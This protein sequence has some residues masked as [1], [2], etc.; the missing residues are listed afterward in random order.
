[1]TENIPKA[2]DKLVRSTSVGAEQPIALQATNRWAYME[3]YANDFQDM[4]AFD[5]NQKVL[6]IIGIAL[7]LMGNI[8]AV[9]AFA[10]AAYYRIQYEHRF[11]QVTSKRR[12][13][14]AN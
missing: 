11:G 7:L 6:A 3:K 5:L 12:V 10:G 4:I 9:L 8:L 1:M 13:I 14:L 2:Y